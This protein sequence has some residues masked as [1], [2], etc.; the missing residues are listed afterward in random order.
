[1]PDEAEPGTGISLT[2]AEFEEAVAR[3]KKV[4]F[5]I[6]QEAEQ[7]WPSFVGWRVNYERAAYAIAWAVSAP[8]ALWSGPRRSGASP[9]PPLRPSALAPHRS[10]HSPPDQ[11]AAGPTT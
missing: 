4:D 5:P 10:S 8:P 11:E 7:A 6:E 3:L 2:Y 1:V 9:I